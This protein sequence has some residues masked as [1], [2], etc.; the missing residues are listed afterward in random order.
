MKKQDVIRYFDAQ[1]STWDERMVRRDPVI[2]RIFD[3]AGVREGMKILDVG[4]G[5][6]VLFDAYLRRK[7]GS[8]T[9]VD[10]SPEMA[11]RA[12]EKYKAFPQ[13]Q[14]ICADAEE[15][16]KTGDYDI[17]M[18]YNAFPHFEDPDRLIA[19]LA[20]MCHPGGVVCIAHGFSRETINRR[21][22]KTPAQISRGLMAAEELAGHMEKLLDVFVVISDDQMYQVCGRVRNESER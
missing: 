19:S 10:I 5:T 20:Q 16:E 14:V 2:E 9:A 21:H 22:G 13:I 3:G 12:A 11:R 6:G 17:C 15:L 8:V 18:V 7:A 1:A 4:C